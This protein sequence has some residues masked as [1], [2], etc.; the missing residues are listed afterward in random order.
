[1][2]TLILTIMLPTIAVCGVPLAEAPKNPDPHEAKVVAAEK[3]PVL[4]KKG[5]NPITSFHMVQ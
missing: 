3:A 4:L 1:M 2:K 5:Q